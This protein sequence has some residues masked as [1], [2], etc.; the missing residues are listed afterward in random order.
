MRA[1]AVASV[2]AVSVFLG[3]A[4]AP[5][6]LSYRAQYEVT[7]IPGGTGRD[8]AGIRGRLVTEFKSCTGGYSETQR[9]VADM[10]NSDEQTH[11][12]DFSATTWESTDGKSFDFRISD[13]I[14]GKGAQ[15]YE[16]R[17]ET[18]RNGEGSARFT[19]PGGTLALPQGTLFPT[20]YA[21]RLIAAARA[22]QTSFSATVFH[23]DD[24][25]ELLVASAFIGGEA[26]IADREAEN[27]PA[28]KD[29]RSWPMVISYYTL[30]SEDAAPSYEMSFRGYENGVATGMRTR[31]AQFS[32]Q[33][34]LVQL[35]VLTGACSRPAAAPPGKP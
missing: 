1:L 29:V 18:A 33:S 9:F 17:A 35:D 14:M 7:L 24:V 27:A 19:V 13:V 21:E 22:G 26:T 28:L 20:E 34:K 3:A 23:G 11:R 15:R 6:L 5:P 2:V 10:T 25:K 16:G 8:I 31:Y 4:S 32:L 12:A 30:G